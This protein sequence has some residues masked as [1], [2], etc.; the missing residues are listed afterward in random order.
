M[1]VRANGGNW[2]S[3]GVGKIIKRLGEHC[4]VEYFDA[5]TSAPVVHEIEVVHLEAITLPEQTRVYHYN[6][7]G[8]W[9]IGRILDDQGDRQ[10]VRFPNGVTKHLDVSDVFVRWSVPIADPTPFLANKINESPRF[11]DGRSAFMRSLIAQRAASM[12]MSALLSSAVELEAHQ[13]EVVRRI[14][15]DPVQRYLLA[16]EVGLGKTIEAGVLIRQCVLDS[17]DDA[18]IL[19]LVPEPLIAQWRSELS[20]KFFLEHSLD[21]RV[22]VIAHGDADRIRSLIGKATMLVIDE[23]HHLTDMRSTGDQGIYHEIAAA[24]SEIERILLLSATPALHNERGFLRML[25]LLDAKTYPLDGEAAFRRKIE[26]R[27]VLAEIVAGLTPE[28]VLYLDYT[29]DQLAHLFPNDGLMQEHASALH[30]VIDQMPGEDDPG[31]IEAIGRV[32]AHLSE[33]YRLHRRIL[34]HRRRSI[35]GLTPDRSGVQIIEYSSPDMAALTAAM[36]DWRFAEVSHLGDDQSGKVWSDRVRA[37][38]QVLDRASHY[39]ISG[40]GGIG[41][42]AR[43]PALIGDA[44]R[45]GRIERLLARP[46]LFQDRATALADALP[47]LLSRKAQCVIFCSDP[48]TADALAKFLADRLNKI[49]DRHSPDD[50]SWL[51]FND[52][53]THAILVCDRR[54][55]EGLNL[56]GGRK[57]VVHYDVPFNPNRIEQRLGRADRYGSGDP[58]LSLVLQCNDD[59]LGGAWTGYL[60]TGLRVFSRSVASLQYLIDDTIRGLSSALFSDGSEAL[61]DLTRESAGEQGIIER[62]IRNIDQQDALDALG[63][64]PTQLLDDLSDIDDDWRSIAADTTVWL[65]RTLQFVRAEDRTVGS[66]DVSDA[67]PFRYHYSTSSRHTLIPLATVMEHCEPSLDVVSNS[68]RARA[69]RTIPYTFRR[70]TA[71]TRGARNAGVG[72]LRYGDPFIAGMTAITEA[73]DRGRSFAMWRFVPGYKSHQSADIFLR[74]DFVVEAD[75]ELAHNVL[76]RFG[77]NQSASTAAIR[78]RGDMALPPFFKTVWLTQEFEPVEDP[79]LL[80]VLTRPYVPEPQDAGG[81]DFN[82]NARRWESVRRLNIPELD[83]WSEFCSKARIEAEVALR[84]QGDLTDK[85]AMAERRAATVDHGRLGQLRARIQ[86]DAIGDTPEHSELLFEEALSAALRDGIRAPHVRVDTIGAVFLS[87]NQAA[88]IAISGST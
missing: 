70:R 65:E 63:M 39:P 36:D 51:V 32:H 48:K 85:L 82:L 44:E 74:F 71:L 46:G 14:L 18:W 20:S 17:A 12:G 43:R 22:H 21:K 54:A 5:P 3:L 33:V 29:I 4:A 28:N 45:F 40:S 50:D 62:E 23:A 59:P 64:P 61:A 47:P 55:E 75:L 1:L 68:H 10:L 26:A 79:A 41:F 78:R 2:A 30:A 87:N 15:Q 24:V 19:V 7:V 6:S 56:Q 67:T 76:D 73:D 34:R 88:T 8:A 37:F 86:N 35:G 52:D 49:V 25:H 80:E 66:L 60:S 84:I 9:E 58:V 53:P 57:I 83:Y 77:R 42:L 16:D 72:L 31:L 81:R 38:W 13:I 69:I 11:S 27:Q